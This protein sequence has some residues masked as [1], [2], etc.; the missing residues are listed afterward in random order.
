MDTDGARDDS[1]FNQDPSHVSG[2]GDWTNDQAFTKSKRLVKR[3]QF[4]SNLTELEV[5]EAIA[6][7]NVQEAVRDTTG[8]SGAKA[9]L[10]MQT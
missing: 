8:S 7:D 10:E 4:F 5:P 1:K 6:R 2:L 3:F 9:K